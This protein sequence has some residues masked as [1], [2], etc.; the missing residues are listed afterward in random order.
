MLFLYVSRSNFCL[1]AVIEEH[2]PPEFVP[3]LSHLSV[4]QCG[5]LC[6]VTAHLLE[7]LRSRFSLT[8]LSEYNIQLINT[9]PVRS[10]PY[11][12]APC[13][14]QFLREH[15][16]CLLEDEV[17]LPTPHVQIPCFSSQT[18]SNLHSCGRLL[19]P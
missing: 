12:T 11:K 14:M 2:Q 16:K 1:Q 7:V 18:G 4:E 5:C 6:E 10:T 8:H 13:K 3:D 15:I 19:A 17:K 9:K